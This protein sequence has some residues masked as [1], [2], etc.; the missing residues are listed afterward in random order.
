[1]WKIDFLNFH[2]YFEKM[3]WVRDFSG[4]IKR[5]LK[6]DFVGK[7]IH[8][9]DHFHFRKLS[10]K[11]DAKISSSLE[12]KQRIFNAKFYFLWCNTL[13][14]CPFILLVIKEYVKSLRIIIFCTFY[15][16]FNSFLVKLHALNYLLD[17]ILQQVISEQY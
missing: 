3:S 15:D 10:E 8:S 17:F 14:T 16:K 6:M 4:K 9:L 13:S 5:N 1:M 11:W 7:L 12:V 2:V